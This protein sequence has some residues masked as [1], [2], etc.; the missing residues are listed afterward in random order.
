MCRPYA[1][2]APGFKYSVW[3]WRKQFN[4]IGW[5]LVPYGNGALNQS[6]KFPPVRVAIGCNPCGGPCQAPKLTPKGR[7]PKEAGDGQ[8][9][10]SSS[11]SR[12]PGEA[13]IRIPY[14]DEANT[15]LSPGEQACQN[16]GPGRNCFC[17]FSCRC[18]IPVGF[19]CTTA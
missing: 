4:S 3:P 15:R 9:F 2:R 5:D 7:S 16:G 8:V 19:R 14:Y 12:P 6:C 13:I 1:M 10:G 18:L 11:P 17:F